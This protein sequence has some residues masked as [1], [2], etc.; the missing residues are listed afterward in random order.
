[1][2]HIPDSGNSES[3]T[4][5]NSAARDFYL[6]YLNSPDWR[7]RRNAA[8]RR[9]GF[10]CE[11][12]N[13]K[14]DLQAHHKTYERL[15]AE[16]DSDIEVL[17]LLCHEG[18]TIEQTLRSPAGIYLK[19][20]SA[21]LEDYPSGEI[22]ELTELVKRVCV[23]HRIVYDG[24]AI[25]RAL[26][27]VTGKRFK[28]SD[29]KRR[30]P[31]YVPDPIAIS[32]ADAHEILSRLQIL[33]VPGQFGRLLKSMPEVEKTPAQQRAHEANIAEQSLEIRRSLAKPRRRSMR[34]RLEAIFAGDG[35]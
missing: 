14:R 1:M 26:E 33:A 19:L 27:L 32:A 31:E 12:C 4:A 35:L 34:E 25:H 8:L 16:R 7:R 20:A 29:L 17:C 5:P 21:V 11:R 18:E 6:A 15:G 28:P 9:A 2:D 24:P 13:S 22:G 10:R 3:S 30:A 23:K